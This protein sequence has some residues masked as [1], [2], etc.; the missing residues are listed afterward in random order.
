[1]Y[2]SGTIVDE[3]YRRSWDIGKVRDMVYKTQK[4]L[5]QHF[6]CGGPCGRRGKKVT[7]FDDNDTEDSRL[8]RFGE[9]VLSI[10]SIDTVLARNV[11]DLTGSPIIFSLGG[12]E[13]LLMFLIRT[14]I[15]SRTKGSDI[16]PT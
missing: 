16:V 8:K 13:F 1:M 12:L 3:V 14:K 5:T 6:R 4:I 2:S 11:F 10:T 9:T 15:F 7:C